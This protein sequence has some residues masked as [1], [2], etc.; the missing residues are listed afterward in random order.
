MARTKVL[1]VDDEDSLRELLNIML[2]KEG[3]DVDDTASSSEALEMMEK[4]NYPVVLSDIQMPQDLSGIE[5]LEEIGRRSYNTLVIMMTAYAS[6]E[7]AISALNNGAFAYITKPFNNDEVKSAIKRAID[8]QMLREENRLLKK[9]LHSSIEQRP[10]IGRSKIMKNIYETIDLVARSDSTILI[11]GESGT[12]K[13]LIAREIHSRSDRRDN[14]FI[15]IN[16]GALTETLLESE[17]FG[18]V[19]GSF[20]GASRDKKGLFAEAEG[21]TFF[22]DEIGETSLSTQVKLLRVLQEWEIIPVGSTKAIPINVRLIAATNADLEEMV[23]TGRFRSDLFYRLSVIP[24]HVPPLRE[25]TDDI[26]LLCDHF[27][28]KFSNGEKTLTTEALDIIK[29]YP[30]PGNVREL[31]NLI[32]QLV[33]LTKHSEISPDDLPEKIKEGEMER[34]G[35]IDSPPNPTLEM[36]EK[37]YIQW[38]LTQTKWHKSEAATILGIDPS[39]LSRKIT[40]YDLDPRT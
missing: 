4:N 2:T 14:K 28:K 8:H 27:L 6:L 25:R 36:I 21:G 33:V 31:E 40:R 20:T 34:L 38:I 18:H 15:S 3:Y 35:E 32:E 1:V 19:K 10:I 26:P 29:D 9:Q 11:H 17:L 24:I 39:T 22:L 16:C 5:M 13:E 30:W 7:S 23:K 12:G 37:A